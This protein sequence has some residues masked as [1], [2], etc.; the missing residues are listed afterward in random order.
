[1][2]IKLESATL[3]DVARNYEDAIEEAKAN[4][5]YCDGMLEI[6]GFLAE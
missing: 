5:D 6:R 3:E 1:M 4:G 2:V